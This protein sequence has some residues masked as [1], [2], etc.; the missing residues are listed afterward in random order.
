MPCTVYVDE[1]GD[2]GVSKIRQAGQPG[3]SDYF[4]MGAVV[5]QSATEI[6]ARSLLNK[7]QRDFGKTKRWKHATDLS[8]IQRVHF[9]REL[10]RLHV[11]FFGLISYKPTLGKYKEFINFDPHMFYNKCATYLLERVGGYLASV[12]PNLTEPQ[13]VFEER[14]HD[15]DMMIRYI[16]KCKEN[17]IYP[18]SKMLCSI[19]PFAITR[20]SKNEED[21][22]RI[23]DMVSN[24]LYACVN[25]TPDNYGITETRY[26]EEL[27]NR[28][29]AGQNCKILDVGIKCIHD[30]QDLALDPPVGKT[31]KGLRSSPIRVKGRSS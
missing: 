10:S 21:L 13:I 2:T 22:L 25:K 28:F 24:S 8:H 11:R 20:K 3:S 15:Y 19:N 29:A 31:L 1:S 23:A 27:A 12:D 5:F 26:L 9:C 30:I 6:Q 18:Q 14:N 16:G 17:P 4:T 7:L